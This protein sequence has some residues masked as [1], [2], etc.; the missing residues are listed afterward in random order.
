MEYVD[1]LE[2]SIKESVPTDWLIWYN[3]AISNG[4]P[5]AKKFPIMNPFHALLVGL[6][7]LLI[8]WVLQIVMKNRKK[9]ELYYFSLLHNGVMVLLNFYMCYEI[10]HQAIVGKYTF[11]GNG[12][13]H[14][15]SGLP[16]A[17]VLWLFYFSKPVEFIDTIIMAL[18]KNNRQISFLHVYHHVATFWIWWAVIF[19]APGGDTYFSA[20]QNAFIHILMYSHYFLATLKVPAPWKRYLTQMQMLQFVLNMGQALY[21]MTVPT[22][23]P[24]ALAYLLFG[25]MISLLVL[26]GNFYLKSVA[27]ASANKKAAQNP[28]KAQ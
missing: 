23:Y 2:N 22:A 8:I 5:N 12:V 16:M 25:Y 11:I 4:D 20:A 28:K 6:A 9:F 3:W 1:S 19:Y 7:Y 26:F 15:I 17:R 18:K 10:I 24:K 14:T 21:V 13:D 27:E